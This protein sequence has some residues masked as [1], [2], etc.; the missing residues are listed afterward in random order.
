MPLDWSSFEKLP[1][2]PR[3]NFEKLCRGIVRM[4]WGKFGRFQALKNQPGVE[5][6]LHLNQSCEALGNV[7]QWY[8]WQCKRFERTAAGDLKAAS[9]AD[10]EDSLQKTVTVLPKLTDWVLWTPFTLSKKDQ[11]WFWSLKNKC[12]YTLHLWSEEEI[13]NYLAGPALLLRSTYFGEL[14]VTPEILNKQHEISI[15]PVKE[16]WMHPAHQEVDAERTIRRM[17]GE[18]SAWEDA[19]SLGKRLSDAANTIENF[20]IGIAELDAEKIN[21][22]KTCKIFSEMLLQFHE[23][24]AEADIEI[25]QQWLRDRGNLLN[26]SSLIFLKTIRGKNISLAL[27]VTNAFDDI[28]QAQFL[29]DEVAAYLEIGLVAILADAGGGKTHMAAQITSAQTNR[30]AGVFLHGR[31]FHKG[32][33]KDDLARHFS[34]DGNPLTSMEK[35]LASLDAAAKRSHCRLPVIIDGLN[36]AENPKEWRDVLNSIQELVKDYPNVLVICTLR[37]GEHSRERWPSARYDSE[38]RESFAV[39]ALPDDIERLECEGFGDDLYPAL[40]KYF[41]YYKINCEPGTEIPEQFLNHPLNLRIFCD[42]INP[43]RDAVVEIDYLPASLSYLFDEY[44]RNACLRIS[45]MK[46]APYSLQQVNDALYELG[47]A[48]W[49]KNDRDISDVEFIKKIHSVDREWQINIVNLLAQ[50]G[51]VFRNPGNVPGSYVITPVYDALGG[52]IMASSLLKREAADREFKWLSNAFSIGRF[53]GNSSHPLSYDT[54]KSLAALTPSRMYGEQLWKKIPD[55]YKTAALLF[56]INLDPKYIDQDTVNELTAMVKSKDHRQKMFE[57]LWLTKGAT[58]H[59]LNAEFLDNALRDMQVAERDL[60]WTEWLRR[61]QDIHGDRISKEISFLETKWIE[62]AN[63]R[64]ASDRLRAKALSW[65]LTTTSHPLR[66][67]TTKA[68]Y[69]F[70]RGDPEFL[71]DLTIKSL[72]INDPYISERLLAASYGV[73]TAL[74]N[75]FSSNNLFTS[76]SLTKFAGDIFKN[77]FSSSAPYQT[78]HEFSRDFASQIIELTQ[79]HNPN[80]FS[81]ED[82]KRTQPPFEMNNVP[83]WG[84]AYIPEDIKISSKNGKKSKF[85]ILADKAKRHVLKAVPKKLMKH[86]SPEKKYTRSQSPFYMDFENYTIGRL[87]PDRGNYD[88]DHAEYKKIKAQLLWR[89]YKLGWSE[90]KFKSAEES[91]IHGQRYY[92]RT[93]KE[94]LKTDRYGKKYSWIAYH[95]M[96]GLL[97]DKGILEERD[98]WRTEAENIDPSFLPPLVSSR[99]VDTNYLGDPNSSTQEWIQNGE[100]PDFSDY[101]ELKNLEGVDGPCIALDGHINQEDKDLGRSTFFFVRSFLVHEKDKEQ[102]LTHLGQENFEGHRLPQKPDLYNTFWCEVPWSKMLQDYS[103]QELS[104]VVNEKR[105]T[106]HRPRFEVKRDEEGIQFITHD[107]MEEY[108]DTEYEY[109]KFNVIDAVCDLRRDVTDGHVG[110][111]TALSKTVSLNMDLVGQP[112]SFDLYT[113][114]GEVVTHYINYNKDGYKNSHSLLYIRKNF[115]DKFIK[116]RKLSLVWLIWGERNYAF[117]GHHHH[118]RDLPEPR[119]AVFKKVV[120]YESEV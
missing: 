120:S 28:R 104:F 36:E 107:E 19:V 29:F 48:L 53:S 26:E 67:A 98:W 25:I 108:Q 55:E 106:K 100:I 117:H 24:L 86:I 114:S 58:N 119:Y 20:T 61:N 94:K 18:P 57:R 40:E 47:I 14:I 95:E 113:K 41:N 101:L 3:D 110:N 42:I 109:E 4:N 6:H 62:D 102:V 56:T 30:P 77:I 70:G 34:I 7:D 99:L 60:N 50:E 5:F 66:T 111:I 16:R 89:V 112:Q 97:R 91:I 33:N 31:N 78:T 1:G 68:L 17:L 96:A 23:L 103:N 2:D 8:G 46:N 80:Y 37:T 74:T 93:G 59:P 22:A 11:E 71:F 69:W 82:Y 65:L 105:V 85:F 87:V 39:Q 35:L 84:E 63:S 13:D 9:K 76:G 15:A 75:N 38:T 27:E 81:D 64:T 90:E 52:H 10:I 83:G 88:Y 54:F 12:T 116:D 72:S 43:K 44:I 21:F 32:Q 49:D 45:N 51:I 73:A 115:L 79:Y 92:E 118:H